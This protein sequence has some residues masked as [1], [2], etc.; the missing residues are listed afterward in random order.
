MPKLNQTPSINKP[1]GKA[2]ASGAADI[3][4][5]RRRL[6]FII[7]AV[8][9]ALIG[10]IVG[11]SLYFSEDARYNRLTVITVD[12]TSVKM[13]YLLKRIRL[14]GSEP[15]DMVQTLMNEQIV[16]IEAPRYVGEVTAEDVDT[17]LRIMASGENETISESEFKEW[18][19]QLLNELDLSDSEYRDMVA[20]GILTAS[21]HG[22]LAERVPTVAEQVYL[23][24]TYLS[25]AEIADIREKESAGEDVGELI[26]G[27]WQERESA[28]AVEEIGWMPRGVLPAGWDDIVFSLAI[29]DISDPVPYVDFESSDYETYYYLI[30]VS[31]KAEAREIDEGPLQTIKSQV[32]DDWLSEEAKSHEI[33]LNY[34]SEINAWINWQIS[35]N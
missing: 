13:D 28:E 18:Y 17:A 11:V 29:G 34:N 3:S 25:E 23:Y 26:S 33:T 8:V 24:S 27:I 6:T 9:I 35:K 32:L 12:D 30:M 21:F 22:Y 7:T 31:E 16:K 10:I 14:S 2:P 1:K 19:R 5:R 15:M 4:R 20:T